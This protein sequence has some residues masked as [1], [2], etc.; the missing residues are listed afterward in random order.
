M[1]NCLSPSWLWEEGLNK[2]LGV[3]LSSEHGTL[4]IALT[5][6]CCSVLHSYNLT[7][8][9]ILTP[10]L[11]PSTSASACG[12]RASARVCLC[13]PDMPD[14]AHSCS[15]SRPNAVGV[16]SSASVSSLAF[17]EASTLFVLSV[18]SVAI[19]PV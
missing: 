11:Q 15:G 7:V 6:E 3:L 14:A 8:V 17:L 10:Q 1:G 4:K 13:V 16:F 2:L 19:Y 12:H 9:A 18:I 5:V